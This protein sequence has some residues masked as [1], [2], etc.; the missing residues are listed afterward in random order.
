VTERAAAV[1]VVVPAYEAGATL[2]AVVRGV[3]SALPAAYVVAVDD[4]SS[5]D[6]HTVAA[7]LC[8][9]TIRFERNRG[10]GAAL[11]AGFQRALAAGAERV[12]TMDAD[13]QH[14]PAFAPRLLDALA[15]ADLAI[16]AR[17][18]RA[19]TAMP[20]SRRATN[21][22]SARVMSTIARQPIADAQSGYRA[23]RRAV[24][25]SVQAEG[26]RYEYETD[27]LLG[28]A[29]AGFR[30]AAVPVPTVYG[31]R[32]HFRLVSDAWLVTRCIWRHRQSGRR[33][34]GVAGRAELASTH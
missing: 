18:R 10:K 29:R 6:T 25:E 21:A 23:I 27:L 2:A 33:Q 12:V 8:D 4:G 20:L 30:L 1:F 17:A 9:E 19:G 16:G 24:L 3:R 32:S 5:D 15:S 34:R 28:A 31:P 11:R 14:D 26:D 7:A 13:G 22:L